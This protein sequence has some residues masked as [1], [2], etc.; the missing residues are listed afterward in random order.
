MNKKIK[1]ILQLLLAAGLSLPLY[2]LVHELGH[3][4]VMLSAGATVED[5]SIFTAHVIAIGGNYTKLGEL[6]LQVNG[7]FLPV[8]CALVYLLFYQKDRESTFYH[9]FSYVVTMFPIGSMLAWVFIPFLYINGNAPVNDDV[10]HFLNVF[11][12]YFHPLIVSAV[13]VLIIGIGIAVMAKKEIVQN[14]L[15]IVKEK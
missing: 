13:A 12:Q 1:N 6:W 10:T 14:I 2:I 8:I 9:Y 5:F 15:K 4:I 3:L 11:S 7:A